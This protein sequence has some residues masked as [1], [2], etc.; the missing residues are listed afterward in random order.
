MCYLLAIRMGRPK[1]TVSKMGR[2]TKSDKTP[3]PPMR[4]QVSVEKHHGI[5]DINRRGAQTQRGSLHAAV[6][7]HVGY[8]FC[9]ASK[10]AE[11]FGSP[12]FMMTA[13]Q[14]RFCRGDAREVPIY[15]PSR[16]I[17]TG[18][19]IPYPLF[20]NRLSHSGYIH[21]EPSQTPQMYHVNPEVVPHWNTNVNP[22]QY[23]DSFRSV[24]PLSN[25]GY[26]GASSDM[27]DSKFVSGVQFA[28]DSCSHNSSPVV[29]EISVIGTHGSDTSYDLE[30]DLDV[31]L[32]TIEHDQC[33][34]CEVP[35]PWAQSDAGIIKTE[36]KTKPVEISCR[37]P[38]KVPDLPFCRSQTLVPAAE[39]SNQWSY[40]HDQPDPPFHGSIYAHNNSSVAYSSNLTHPNVGQ[41]NTTQGLGSHMYNSLLMAYNCSGSHDSPPPGDFY[42]GRCPQMSPSHFAGPDA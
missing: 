18:P 25:T 30:D 2:R 27:D 41:E 14:E 38:T 7:N 3:P 24:A 15:P 36:L 29:S 42:Q 9:S 21:Q 6:T 40:V 12:D 1:K 20:S 26:E 35:N 4:S 13:S 37:H 8:E 17:F 10:K 32:T 19:K 23:A 11:F 39:K 34:C 33:Q 22:Y 5:T 28:P 31:I 16:P